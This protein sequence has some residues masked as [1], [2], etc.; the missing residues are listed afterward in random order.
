MTDVIVNVAGS[1]D[2]RCVPYDRPTTVFLNLVEPQ[3]RAETRE[4]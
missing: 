2:V 4:Q 3:A 1:A